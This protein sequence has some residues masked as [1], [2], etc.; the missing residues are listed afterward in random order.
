VRGFLSVAVWRGVWI[1]TS[2]GMLEAL[3]WM[4]MVLFFGER[5][6]VVEV[7]WEVWISSGGTSFWVLLFIITV[8]CGGCDTD[9]L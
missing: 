9:Y 5:D 7:V 4:R 6:D 2:V 3:I 8:V 1:M